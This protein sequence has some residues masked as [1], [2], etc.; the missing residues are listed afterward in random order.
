MAFPNASSN[1][2][3]DICEDGEDNAG[4]IEWKWHPLL[5]CIQ[6]PISAIR[7][8]GDDAVICTTSNALFS[9]H[10][11]PGNPAW[12][13]MRSW[14]ME[15]AHKVVFSGE[16]MAT[17][18]CPLS[19]LN[20][21]SVPVR[22]HS[23]MEPLSV[24]SECI[25]NAL[26]VGPTRSGAD[27]FATLASDDVVATNSVWNIH[28]TPQLGIYASRVQDD[29]RLQLRSIAL[30]MFS[31][32]DFWFLEENFVIVNYNC[33][34]IDVYPNFD[35]VLTSVALRFEDWISLYDV[36]IIHGRLSLEIYWVFDFRMIPDDIDDIIGT[37]NYIT[38]FD[39]SD[40]GDEILFVDHSLRPNAV[41]TVR[42]ARLPLDAGG[43]E[44]AST[45]FAM[46]TTVLRCGSGDILRHVNFVKRYGNAIWLG[47]ANSYLWIEVLPQMMNGYPSEDKAPVLKLSPRDL[48]MSDIGEMA[49]NPNWILDRDSKESSTCMKDEDEDIVFL[50]G[51]VPNDKSYFIGNRLHKYLGDHNLVPFGNKWCS[52]YGFALKGDFKLVMVYDRIDMFRS[53]IDDPDLRERIVISRWNQATREDCLANDDPPS[54]DGTIRGLDV[55][56]LMAEY[57]AQV[58]REAIEDDLSMVNESGDVHLLRVQLWDRFGFAPH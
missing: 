26:K 1:D 33:A 9:V 14:G 42:A 46:T 16:S 55:D 52:Q 18:D 39:V 4:F 17:T 25:V 30:K 53:E 23:V 31:K 45:T 49:I 7:S 54:P 37:A 6:R 57:F 38:C 19:W 12:T 29:C 27:A 36:A 15:N 13:I 50:T 28:L 41:S 3:E 48:T 20:C 10:H 56:A 51:P 34:S 44:P 5:A 22:H 2:G 32:V 35:T 43:D 8:I 47:R 58:D 11:G 40:E 21:N 24:P